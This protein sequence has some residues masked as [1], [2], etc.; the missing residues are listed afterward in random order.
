MILKKIDMYGTKLGFNFKRKSTY[1][2]IFGGISTILTFIIYILFFLLFSQDLYFKIN[3]KVT[4]DTVYITENIINNY[5]FTKESF[6]FAFYSPIHFK[7]PKLYE[8]S[9]EYIYEIENNYSSTK[10][11][12]ISCEKTQYIYLFDKYENATDYYCLDFSNIYNQNLTNKYFSSEVSNN[13]LTFTVN[14]NFTYLSTLNETYKQ[15][16]LK[17][18]ETFYFLYP[19]ISFSPNNYEFPLDI[20]LDFS[21]FDLNQYNY[22]QIDLKYTEI[23]VEQD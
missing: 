13:F 16:L 1:N 4:S 12:F 20:H 17:S 10:L 15:I 2:S 21:F 14:Y 6:L 11:D 3:P 23:K 8:F 9:I 22:N 18:Y 19:K 7:D 5:T